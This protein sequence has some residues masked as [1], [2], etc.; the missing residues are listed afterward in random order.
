MGTNYYIAENPCET[1]GRKERLHIGKSSMGWVFSLHVMPDRGINA[2]QD[3]LPLF[4]KN[5]IVDE[6]GAT[7]SPFEMLRIIVG[8]GRPDRPD[9]DNVTAKYARLGPHNLL[10]PLSE[11]FIE[12]TWCHTEG[13]FS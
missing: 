11:R 1:C 6:Y 13:D 2:L 8:R 9:M 5:K 12:G 4:E 10:A 3:W 7:I